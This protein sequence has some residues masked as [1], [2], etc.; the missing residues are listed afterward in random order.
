MIGGSYQLYRPVF[1]FALFQRKVF[2]FVMSFLQ[3][4]QQTPSNRNMSFL[5]H[6]SL[7]IRGTHNRDIC[8]IEKDE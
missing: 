7:R 1:L 8:G 3:C 2:S 4:L 6:L 5:I